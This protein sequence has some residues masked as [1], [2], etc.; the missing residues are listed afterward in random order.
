MQACDPV[1]ESGEGSEEDTVMRIENHQQEYNKYYS[2]KCITHVHCTPSMTRTLDPQ[3]IS[4]DW[5][6]IKA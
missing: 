1:M 2:E 6:T 3:I 5:A 4:P